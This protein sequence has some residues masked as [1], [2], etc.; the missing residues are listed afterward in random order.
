MSRKKH[1]DMGQQPV[2][3]P[4]ETTEKSR[5]VSMAGNQSLFFSSSGAREFGSVLREV[6][7]AAQ[8]R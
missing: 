8:E 6:Q 7:T 3:V 5:T 4:S 2:P 1:G